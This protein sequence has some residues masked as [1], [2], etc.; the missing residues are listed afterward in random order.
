MTNTKVL[1]NMT[2]DGRSLRSL[3]RVVTLWIGYFH[4]MF[5]PDMPRIGW[6][7]CGEN[8]RIGTCDI[9]SHLPVG[10]H[11]WH[12]MKE[13]W[14]H[15]ATENMLAL[16]YS[17]CSPL[18]IIWPW[19]VLVQST[20]VVLCG[21]CALT[22][23]RLVPP[24]VLIG[25]TSGKAVLEIKRLFVLKGLTAFQTSISKRNL[26]SEIR[27]ILCRRRIGLGYFPH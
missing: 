18:S 21:G 26:M 17:P 6:R 1:N 2:S 27:W 9:S 13:L 14:L 20:M 5:A 3:W 22:V 10:F 24:D 16:T 4:W 7:S 25:L 8:G 23:V 12:L 15:T 11:A 19:Y